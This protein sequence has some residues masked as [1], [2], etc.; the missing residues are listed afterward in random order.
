MIQLVQP[1]PVGANQFGLDLVTKITTRTAQ[2]RPRPTLR[3]RQRQPPRT[4]PMP[5]GDAWGVGNY[6]GSTVGPSDPTNVD[7]STILRGG[8]GGCGHSTV[9]GMF[10]P[11]G[12]R[13]R[14]VA[15]VSPPNI[16]LTFAAT[17][18]SDG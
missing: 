11:T 6:T 9:S 14:H 7:I 2:F 15:T 5:A 17:L 10:V 1:L 8:T 18:T 3:Q 16:V 13:S 4:A 12:S